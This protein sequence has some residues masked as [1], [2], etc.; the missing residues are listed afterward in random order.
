[1]RVEVRMY[2]L[3]RGIGLTNGAAS[4]S[5]RTE[6]ALEIL[7]PQVGVIGRV[8]RRRGGSLC[9]ALGAA[10][11]MSAGAQLMMGTV[12]CMSGEWKATG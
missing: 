4:G 9:L 6:S 5:R 11:Q 10:V 1:M 7:L 2:C 12:Y 8:G 3:F